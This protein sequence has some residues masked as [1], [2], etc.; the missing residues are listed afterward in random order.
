[1]VA[2]PSAA[3]AAS[4]EAPALPADVRQRY[5][6]VQHSAKGGRLVYRAALLGQA[7]LH[8]VNATAKA[9]AWADRGLLAA[10]CNDNA[11]PWDDASLVHEDELELEDEP[12]T[13]AHFDAV[14]DAL[15]R[16]TS[17]KTWT[18]ALK[19]HLYAAQTLTLWRCAAVKQTSMPDEAEG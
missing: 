3:G 6:P 18:T 15:R 9:D 1:A 16:A 12:Q 13:D 10:L 11:A 8:F 7:K 4:D 17:Y 14:S 2:T 19:D 5:L